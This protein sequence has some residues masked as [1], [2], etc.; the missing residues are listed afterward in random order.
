MHHDHD[1]E[2]SS[3]PTAPWDTDLGGDVLAITVRRNDDHATTIVLDGELDLHGADALATALG[4]L[5]DSRPTAIAVDAAGVAFM[6]S[7]GLKTLLQVRR[8]AAVAGIDLR[9]VAA[10]AAVRRVIDM[11]GLG[12]LFPTP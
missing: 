7:S 5:L 10:S 9:L 6:D 4:D 1:H 3:S 8:D 11:A 2:P 12:D